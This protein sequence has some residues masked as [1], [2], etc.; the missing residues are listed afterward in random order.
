MSSNRQKLIH[1]VSL[2]FNNHHQQIQANHVTTSSSSNIDQIQYVDGRPRLIVSI[3]LDLLNLVN[4][5][6]LSHAMAVNN[7]ANATN[8]K[9]N[10]VCNIAIMTI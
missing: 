9:L 2:I 1:P 6:Q 8:A 7:L 10:G 5:N 3:E 4:I